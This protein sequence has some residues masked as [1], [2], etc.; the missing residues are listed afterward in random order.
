MK[1]F[2]PLRFRAGIIFGWVWV[3]MTFFGWVWVGVGE[4]DL[5]LV[6]RGWT[7]VSVIFFWLSVGGF[8]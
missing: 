5:F 1:N 2:L 8:G 4:C 3:G 7:W 6:G